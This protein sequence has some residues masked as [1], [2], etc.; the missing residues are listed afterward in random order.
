MAEGYVE[1][2]TNRRSFGFGKSP[3]GGFRGC[4]GKD[5]VKSMKEN[6]LCGLGVADFGDARQRRR[7]AVRLY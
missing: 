7:T 4:I 1:R 2:K 6:S 3:G 5:E